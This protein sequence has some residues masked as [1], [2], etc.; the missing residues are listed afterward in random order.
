MVLGAATLG[1][2]GDRGGGGGKGRG[3]GGGGRVDASRDGDR[4]GGGKAVV[5]IAG[6]DGR[7]SE[8]SVEI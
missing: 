8:T 3:E 6:H 5:V 7:R 2:G 1:R 4:R